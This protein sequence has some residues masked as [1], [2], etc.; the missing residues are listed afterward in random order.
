MLPINYI[1]PLFK[2]VVSEFN[3]RL[4]GDFADKYGLPIQLKQVPSTLLRKLGEII[5]RKSTL[6][7]SALEL[8]RWS[9]TMFLLKL[10]SF[11]SMRL[12]R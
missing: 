11:F 2:G 9:R 7:E 5:V 3:Q 10:L 6:S 4:I 8:G 1:E 12:Q